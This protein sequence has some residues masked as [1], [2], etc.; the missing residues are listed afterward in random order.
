MKLRCRVTDFRN[1]LPLVCN[2]EYGFLSARTALNGKN[3]IVLKINLKHPF[4]ILH[5]LKAGILID[6]LYYPL[7]IR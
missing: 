3:K 7:Y 1:E 4:A 5:I 2:F 6:L